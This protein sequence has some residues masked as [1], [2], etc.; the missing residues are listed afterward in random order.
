VPS[1]RD[2]VLIE[3]YDK[4]GKP[5]F[6]PTWCAVRTGRYLYA[7]YDADLE[8]RNEELYDLR[9][10]PYQ[11][12]NLLPTSDPQVRSVRNGLLDR[13]EARCDPPPPDFTW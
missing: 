7:R 4:L 6:I 8:S 11:L 12:Q 3:H 10:D 2:T 9:T 13:L 5:D 1:W